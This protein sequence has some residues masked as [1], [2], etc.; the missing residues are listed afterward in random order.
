[1]DKHVPIRLVVAN[2][3][4]FEA[5]KVDVLFTKLHHDELYWLSIFPD[6][7]HSN[8]SETVLRPDYSALLHDLQSQSFDYSP[9]AFEGVAYRAVYPESTSQEGYALAYYAQTN[10]AFP[11][12]QFLWAEAGWF[13]ES[14]AKIPADQV[15]E[16]IGEML[17]L[18][19]RFGTSFSRAEITKH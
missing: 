5:E 2:R 8:F 7:V 6:G 13:D 16:S 4:L 17:V 18:A 11:I 12:V 1:M 15:A 9:V 19:V 14:R 10:L 3:V